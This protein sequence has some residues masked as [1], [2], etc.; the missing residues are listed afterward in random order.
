MISV[1][2][3]GAGDPIVLVHGIGSRWQ[4]F[5]P[6][7]DRLAEHHEVIAIDLPGFGA[8]PLVDGVR[9]G[10]RGYADWLAG[11]LAANDVARP[12][13]VGSSMGGGVALELGRA[14]VASSVTAFS[15]VGFWGTAGL[16][17]T[18]SLLT[19]LRT[20]AR[21]AAPVLNRMLDHPAGRAV[22]LSNMFG[23]PTRIPPEV[24]RAD[25]AGL[26]A[27]TGFA[28]ARK[29]FGSYFLGSDDDP[30]ALVDVP[31][32]IAWGTRDVVLIHRSQSA[33]AREVLPFARHVDL[34]GCGHLPFNDDPARCVGLI[35]E[36]AAATK[37]T[38]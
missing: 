29:D 17:W 33:R 10:P 23:H 26:A 1:D 6:V 7:L 35:L 34:A 18:Q 8:S 22:L 15:P 32:T 31:V 13:L 25:L 24:A 11:W 9:P 37:E 28:A 19:G 21:T 38:R 30:G 5:E 27:A 16:R 4:S 20:G 2:R 12:H 3:R 36:N 14:G